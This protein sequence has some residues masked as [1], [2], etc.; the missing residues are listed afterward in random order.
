MRDILKLAMGHLRMM[1][2]YRWVALS[3]A[4][5][6]AVAGWLVVLSLPNQYQVSAKIFIDTRSMLGPLLQ[7]MVVGNSLA[8]DS[9]LLLRRT[10][11]TRPNLE[12][13]ARRTDMDLE[14]QTPEAF[15]KLISEL[16]SDLQITSPRGESIYTITYDN[17]DPRLAKRVVDELLNTFFESAL[18]GSRQ[19]RTVAEKF[20][21]E[22][23]AAHEQRLYEGEERLKEFRKANMGRLP[24]TGG[25]GFFGRQQQ[26]LAQLEQAKLDLNEATQRRDELRRQVEAARSGK[27]DPA[28]LGVEGAEGATELT[29]EMMQSL[30]EASSPEV[31]QINGR[32]AGLNAQI[33]E[34]LLQYTDKH[35]DIVAMRELIVRLE[36]RKQEIMAGLPPLELTNPEALGERV[37]PILQQLALRLSE[38]EA[39]VAA[40]TSRVQEYGQRVQTATEMA[41]STLEIEAE[42]R[43]LDRDYNL[44]KSRYDQLVRSRESARMTQQVAA[45]ANDS[46]LKML[47]PPRMPLAPAG[48]NRPLLLSGVFGGALAVGLGLAFLLA[49]I[50]PR[51]FTRTELQDFTGLPILGAVTLVANRWRLAEKRMELAFFG[52]VFM[53]L[54]AFYGGLLTLQLMNVDLHGYIARV[55]QG[56]A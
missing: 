55:L 38:A 45:A 1:W 5:V 20:L 41:N 3:T 51:V 6:V 7:G 22:Q 18:G 15:D 17:H 36:E 39:T 30:L 16:S 54:A 9:A 50:N 24:N 53:L 28:S 32:I 4:A 12:Q 27:I 31:M 2:L 48:P 14:A 29:P 44:F 26:A 13:V 21:D 47:E 10:L 11:M 23:I 52:L 19:D 33:D 42:F 46:Q 49:Q 34:M 56:I 35:P 8:S 40:L 25:G 43:R 37:N